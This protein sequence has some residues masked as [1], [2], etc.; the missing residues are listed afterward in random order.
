MAK[1]SNGLR[2][3]QAPV[4]TSK[5]AAGGKPSQGTGKDKRLKENKG[6]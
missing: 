2:P 3:Q 4:K 1:G 6:K 5:V